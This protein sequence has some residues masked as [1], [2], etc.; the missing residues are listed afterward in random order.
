[1]QVVVLR[2]FRDFFSTD[3]G[4]L[5]RGRAHAAFTPAPNAVTTIQTA[6][7]VRKDTVP[8]PINR[9]VTFDSLALSVLAPDVP[10]PAFDSGRH[11][12]GDFSIPPRPCSTRR[13]G[14]DRRLHLLRR[15]RLPG[16]DGGR[17]DAVADR[18]R[19]RADAGSVAA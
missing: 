13:S 11:D 1:M 15:G 18:R 17:R 4:L 7:P 19:A 3:P 2:S 14:R 12:P 9:T 6:L 10:V 16:A 8:D 5:H